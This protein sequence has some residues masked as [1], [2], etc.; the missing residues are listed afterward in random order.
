MKT[1]K[2]ETEKTHRLTIDLSL[3]DWQRLRAAAFLREQPLV[4]VIRD[5]IRSLPD[6]KREGRR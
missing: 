5:L 1:E 4:E 2:R 3:P 6:P